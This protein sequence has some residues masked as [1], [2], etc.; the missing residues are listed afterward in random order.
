MISLAN[1][2][3][4]SHH[5]HVEDTVLEE[6]FSLERSTL[7]TTMLLETILLYILTPLIGNIVIAW[8]G[9]I[10]ALSLWRFYN[11]YDYHQHPARNTPLI[12]HEK[13]VIQVWLT[14]LLF[15]GLALFAIPKLD[16]YYQLF[17]FIVLIGISSGTIKALSSDHRTAIGYLAI[18]LLPLTVEMILLMRQD[19]LILSFLV[20]IYFFVQINVLFHSYELSVSAREAQQ[21]IEK[22][23]AALFEKQEI[24]HRFFEQTDEA[25][26]LYD[27]NTRLLDCNQAFERLF[28][29]SAHDLTGYTI[30]TFPNMQWVAM[31]HKALDAESG[32]YFGLYRTHSHHE[33]WL[34]TKCLA[35]EDE[36]GS[37]LGGIGL[38]KDKTAEHVSQ[39]ELA[40]MALHDPMTGLSNRRGFQEYMV[41]L[42]YDE[43]HTTHFSLFFYMDVNKFKQIN[44]RHGHETGDNIIIEVTNRLKEMSPNDANLTRLGGDEFCMVVPHVSDKKKTL[45]LRMEKCMQAIRG[46]FE[47]PF[48]VGNQTFDLRCSTGVVVIEPE[49]MDI[50]KVVAQADVSM[51]QAKR[52]GSG[53]IVLYSNDL[54]QGECQAYEVHHTLGDAIEEEQ[55][56]I[57]Y[58]PI[59]QSD[60]DTVLA[61]EALVRWRHPQ[62]G[63]LAP[64]EFLPVAVRSGQVTQVDTW[65]LQG[66]MEKISTWKREG[67]F[68]LDY[69]SI[70]I[71]VQSLT[72][73]SFVL[74]LLDVMNRYKISGRDIR[75]E[76]T[77]LSLVENFDTIKE[78][79]QELNR[80]GVL[81]IVD[82][83]GTGCL[84][85]LH[86]KDLPFEAIKVD[87][88]FVQKLTERIENIFLIQ[89]IIELAQKFRY[90]IIVKGVESEEQR[91][92]IAKLNTT[93]CHQGSLTAKPLP[94]ETFEQQFFYGENA[95][96]NLSKS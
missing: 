96:L 48:D 2:F 11:A 8:Y 32:K 56:E 37:S 61:A 66:V 1:L 78:T 4:L 39:Q 75:L 42:F 50:D 92:I 17:T 24:I 84:S 58:Q 76:L 51:L 73:K 45:Q 63:L 69:I 47:R 44:D 94:E 20:A 65:V 77:E 25:L 15:S 46:C 55:L 62:K 85:L 68:S 93:I 59:V 72:E 49:E 36:Q 89:T 80:H 81:C 40:H 13:F 71:D 64:N 38:I 12:W 74:D 7:I 31:V 23:K 79:M 26:F 9:I 91:K 60:N 54:E 88:V 86:L 10:M 87:R 30:N 41:N 16:A 5:K 67:V 22:T 28:E 33:L 14:A 53:G 21:E 70:N 19:T 6:L 82:D 83:F 52:I 43:K 35:M 95:S 27:H 34:E 3:K 29:V 18:M 90:D 57:Y